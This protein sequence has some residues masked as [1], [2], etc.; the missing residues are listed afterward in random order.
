LITRW[1]QSNVPVERICL[2]EE[3]TAIR[4]P[5]VF[6]ALFVIT[7]VA[8]FTIGSPILYGVLPIVSVVWL[9]AGL[10]VVHALVQHRQLGW[11]WL[12]VVYIGLFAVN[13]VMFPLL[14]LAACVDS[15]VN[16]RQRFATVL[17][18]KRGE[19]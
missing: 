15:M 10:S 11:L 5:W 12:L 13:K 9:I 7:M 2:K 16:L 17:S 6:S 3:L 8:F 4:I 1:W 14:S 18:E 19:K